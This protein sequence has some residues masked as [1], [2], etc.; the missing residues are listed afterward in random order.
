MA[1]LHPLSAE[2]KSNHHDVVS[3]AS[4][5]E[6]SDSMLRSDSADL[7]WLAGP[8][9][10]APPHVFL[11]PVQSP[12]QPGQKHVQSWHIDRSRHGG[13]S[14][15]TVMSSTSDNTVLTGTDFLGYFVCWLSHV[16]ADMALIIQCRDCEECLNQLVADLSTQF[17]YHGH[18]LFGGQSSC[19]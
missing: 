9:S 13:Y 11:L 18:L 2:L 3:P 14:G 12:M 4:Q 17:L 7:S 15:S 10:A 8:R 5:P 16:T 1:A 6:T 19:S